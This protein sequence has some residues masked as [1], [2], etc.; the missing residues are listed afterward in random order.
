MAQRLTTFI[1]YT[2]RKPGDYHN[3][4]LSQQAVSQERKEKVVKDIK[5]LQSHIL[6]KHHGNVV[7]TRWASPARM[8]DYARI[9]SEFATYDFNAITARQ[10]EI[11][12]ALKN[13]Y[14]AHQHE[15][16]PPIDFDMLTIPQ[17]VMFALLVVCDTQNINIPP[18]WD[19]VGA[20]ADRLSDLLDMEKKQQ[21]L[22]TLEGEALRL[23]KKTASLKKDTKEVVKQNIGKLRLEQ[24]QHFEETNKMKNN[25]TE[26]S[27]VC[28]DKKLKEQ[29]DALV[30]MLASILERNIKCREE[31]EALQDIH[32][33]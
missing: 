5:S 32:N 24:R 1:C 17:L 3:H 15:I 14:T 33:L 20:A 25:I 21:W 6:T 4:E 8:E 13:F 29:G 23:E 26:A 12:V 10:G 11:Y 7:S 30:K 27:R 31:R 9:E 18:I 28:K 16:S 19:R 2:C 22:H